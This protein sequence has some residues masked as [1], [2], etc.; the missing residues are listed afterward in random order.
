MLRERAAQ[1]TVQVHGMVAAGH[2]MLALLPPLLLVVLPV[3][4]EVP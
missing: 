1:L 4:K 2:R 3:V